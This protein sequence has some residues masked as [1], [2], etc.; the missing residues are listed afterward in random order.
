MNNAMKLLKVKKKSHSFY[1]RALK[2]IPYFDQSRFLDNK[3]T[4]ITG[5]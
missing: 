3:K 1:V 2:N 5:F 4:L